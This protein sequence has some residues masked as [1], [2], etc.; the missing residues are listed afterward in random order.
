MLIAWARNV[1]FAPTH[2]EKY[3]PSSIYVFHLSLQKVGSSMSYLI[4]QL[5]VADLN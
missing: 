4:L 5:A 3:G 2:L 1:G